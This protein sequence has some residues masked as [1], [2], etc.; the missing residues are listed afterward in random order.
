M[1]FL[2]LVNDLTK[3]KIKF[4]DFKLVKFKN[5]VLNTKELT[6]SDWILEKIAEMESKTSKNKKIR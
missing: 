6:S 4:D 5:K 1:N 3:L 2:N